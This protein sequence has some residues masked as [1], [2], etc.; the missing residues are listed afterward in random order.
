VWCT[1]F[2]NPQLQYPHPWL[3][4]K[5][6]HRSHASSGPRIELVAAVLYS[7]PSPT[8]QLR[9]RLGLTYLLKRVPRMLR[10]VSSNQLLGVKDPVC[11][12]RSEH[13]VASNADQSDSECERRETQSQ[14]HGHFQ[15][16]ELETEYYF[17]SCLDGYCR[18]ER[19]R[20]LTVRA[21]LYVPSYH[22]CEDAEHHLKPPLPC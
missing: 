8:A 3:A 12:F 21:C 2:E 4:I 14:M 20:E 1:S 6:T 5:R 18:Y 22:Y 9:F 7:R 11:S 16:T 17:R 10:Y 13:P 19:P 15:K